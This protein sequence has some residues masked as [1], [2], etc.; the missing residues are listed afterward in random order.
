[1][2]CA[3]KCSSVGVVAVAM[4]LNAA[5]AQAAVTAAGAPVDIRNA[6][7][8]S[9][10]TRT[11]YQ[12]AGIT[13]AV[14][15]P[16]TAPYAGLQAD[17]SFFSNAY[18]ISDVALKYYD[19]QNLASNKV[20]GSEIALSTTG[21]AT[22]SE[23]AMDI[24]YAH[25]MA[26][27][28]KIVIVSGDSFGGAAQ[29]AATV[30][31]ASV[32]TTSYASYESSYNTDAEK[33][34]IIASSNRAGLA[35]QARLTSFSAAGDTGPYDFPA[36]SPFVAGV[37]ATNLFVNDQGA[38][39]ASRSSETSWSTTGGGTS[40]IFT[41]PAWQRAV[42]SGTFRK[43]PDLAIVGS[44]LNTM[45]VR[46]GGAYS[47]IAGTSL[48]S[49]LWAG[50]MALVQEARTD[51]GKPTLGTTEFLTALYALVGTADYARAFND[52]TSSPSGA[53]N[54]AGPG[55][56][57]ATGLGTPNVPFLIS[58]LTSVPE[59]TSLG[60]AAVALGLLARRVRRA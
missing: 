30:L 56:D 60:T 54:V 16:S 33:S 32:M 26:P 5:V 3:R 14:Y 17:V 29:Y 23:L 15:A 35:A 27:K 52:I 19:S 59:P 48:S 12:G 18:G 28:A 9:G 42:N 43:G 58:Y 24:E 51:A 7:G 2:F 20:S 34:S 36:S 44:G 47:Q 6:Y 55:F 37:G 57:T 11:N 45:P 40:G 13:I 39:T 4:V 38:S 50:I 8:L 10:S 31:G 41:T 49:P 46:V 25:Y 1:M 53:V 21:A 22:S